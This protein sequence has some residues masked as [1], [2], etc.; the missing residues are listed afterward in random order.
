M[1]NR[2]EAL[3]NEIAELLIQTAKEND[4]ERIEKRRLELEQENA[5]LATKIAEL[6]GVMYEISLYQKA[7]IELVESKVSSLFKLVSWKMYSKN[8][9][10]DGETEICEC[11]VDGVPVSTNVNT[12]GAVNA[13]IDII[14][15][16]SRWLGVSFPLW[17]DGKE[18]VTSLIDTNAQLITLQ[19]VEKSPLKVA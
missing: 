19:V 3:K 1:K 16:L 2:N 15:A 17:I 4:I 11:L 5:D 8:L 9:T 13:G 14:N 10:N 18:S 6:D 12:A 7:Y